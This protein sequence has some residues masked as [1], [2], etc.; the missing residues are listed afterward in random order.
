MKLFLDPILIFF[1]A[2]YLGLG[3]LGYISWRS[4]S[5]TVASVPSPTS[6]GNGLTFPVTVHVGTLIIVGTIFGSPTTLI[7]GNRDGN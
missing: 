6:R 7:R 1:L 3:A 4:W 2:V 5:G